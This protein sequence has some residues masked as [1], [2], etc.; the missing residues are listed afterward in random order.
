MSPHRRNSLINTEEDDIKTVKDMR[1]FIGLY[2]TLHI[3]TPNMARFIT[4]L[5]DTVQ[6]LQSK[7]KYK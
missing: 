5:E 7:D 1:S 6:G 3:A 2:K 4:P